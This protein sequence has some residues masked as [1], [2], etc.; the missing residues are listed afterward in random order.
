MLIN[1]LSIYTCLCN[2][3]LVEDLPSRAF[4]SCSVRS[5]QSYSV[6]EVVE[7]IFGTLGQ[8]TSNS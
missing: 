1:T 5:I 3:Y 4:H 2:S 8:A 7:D 6:V